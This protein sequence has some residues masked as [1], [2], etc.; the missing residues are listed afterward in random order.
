VTISVPRTN[1]LSNTCTCLRGLVTVTATAAAASGLTIVSVAFQSSLSGN[2]NWTT[3]DTE[4]V[5]STGSTYTANFDTS[6]LAP[7]FYDVRAV[8]TDSAA[9][10]QASTP[11]RGLAIAN[12]ASTVTLADPGLLASG[13]IT[14]TATPDGGGNFPSQV[15]F[16]SSPAGA[17]N[18]STIATVAT[19]YDEFGNPLSPDLVT[20]FD[21]TTVPDGSYDL[22]VTASDGFNAYVGMVRFGV[23]VDNTPPTSTLSNP[24]GPLSGIVTLTASTQDSSGVVAVV[25]QSS[26]AG[27]GTWT[28]IGADSTAPYAKTFDT[29]ALQDGVY[30][31]RVLATDSAGNTA[32]SP[33][34]SGV[35]VSNPSK[36]S[37]GNLTITDFVA[38]ATNISLLGEIAGSAQHETWAYGY[39]TAPPAIV[40]GAPLPYTV[41]GAN[42]LV[43]LRY[44][45]A[46]GWQI[47]DV[48]RNADGS[49]YRQT[50]G[51]ALELTGQMNPSGEAWLVMRQQV[52]GQ[53]TRVGV[54]HRAPGGQFLLDVAASVALLPILSSNQPAIQVQ[55]RLGQSADG[56]AYG[57]LVAPGQA[58]RTLL[59]PNSNGVNFLVTARLDYGV[60]GGGVWT[61][62]TA[63]LPPGYVP[64]AG[65]SFTLAAADATG[66]GA[67]WAGLQLVTFGKR[68]GVILASFDATGWRFVTATGLDALDATGNFAVAPP[69]SVFVQQIRADSAGI[70]VLATVG[71]GGGSVVA[72]IDGASGQA[73]QSWC[74]SLPRQSLGCDAPLD[75][76]HPAALP[77]AVFATTNGTVAFALASGLLDVY[78]YGAWTST[79]APGFVP[80]PGKALFIAPNDGWLVGANALGRISARSL[81]SPL[82]PWPEANRS[83]LLSVA[84]PPGGNGTSANGALAVGLDG[85][86]LHYDTSAGWIVDAT[87]PRAHHLALRG[88]AFSGPSSATAVGQ[89]GVILRWDGVSWTEDPQSISLTYQQLNAVAFGADGQGWA[90]GAHGTILHYDG[91][92]WSQ[93]QVD[94]ADAGVDITSVAVA[95]QQVFAVADGNLI[96]RGPGGVWQ[97]VDRSLLP[98]QAPSVGDLRLVSGLPD[99]GLVAAGRSLVIVRQSASAPFQYAAQPLEGIAVALAA[100]RAA[101]GQVRAL[102]SIAPPIIGSNGLNT[103]DVGGFPAGDGELMLQT[104]AGWEDLS[105]AQYP[106]AHAPGDGSVQPDPVLAVAAAPDGSSAWAVGGYAGTVTASGLGTHQ[107]L[108]S[109]PFGWRTS[110][111]WRY[112]AGGSVPSPALSAAPATLP[113]QPGTVSFAF[114]TSP[115]CK[116]ECA[117]VRDAQPVV[118]LQAA[119][120]QIAGFATQPGGPGFAV[121]GGD[122]VGPIDDNAYSAG[123]GAVDL[124]RLAGLLSPLGSVPLF[125]AY[126]PRDGVP[127]GTNPAQPWADAFAQAPAPFGQGKVPPG[128]TLVSFGGATGSV[129]RYYAFDATQNGG[130]LR[131]IVLDNSAGSLEDSVP[132][133]TAWLDARLA[134]AQAAGIPV[135]VVVARPLRSTAIGSAS[136]GDAIAAKLATAGALAV[137]TTSGTVYQSQFDRVAVLPGTQIPE[138]EGATLGYQQPQNNGVLWYFVSVD[139]KARKVGVQAIPV[140]A[141]LALEPLAGLTA[142][143][144]STL[145]F[146]AIGRRPVATLATIDNTFPGYDSY[147]S[148]PSPNCA[149]CITPSYSFASSDPTIG[150]FVLP[151]GPGSLYPLLDN[152]G[153]PIPSASSGL[154]CAYNS[155]TTTVSVT[156]GGLSA[157]LP[158]NVKP[159][160]IGRP[161]GTVFRAGVQHV[162]KIPVTQVL[163]RPAGPSTQ[164]APPPPPPAAAPPVKL[165]LPAIVPPPPP[166]IQAAPAPAPKPAPT[167]PPAPAPKLAPPPAPV[168]VPVPVPVPQL[169]AVVATPPVAVPPIPPAVT[170][171]PPGGASA[172]AQATARRE[173]KARRHASQSAY[174]IRPAD[175][176]GTDWFYPALGV[177]SVLAVL[178]AAGGLAGPRPRKALLAWEPYD[179]QRRRRRR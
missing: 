123:N 136:D 32:A 15:T 127:T 85:S 40:G 179:P 38:P 88:V 112:D 63:S 42:Q 83:P 163:T 142:A 16:Q 37:Y 74:G 137:F 98:A 120:A 1:D 57:L 100:F 31:L 155:G 150:D 72:R 122:A 168:P 48:L 102:V 89:L 79:A 21:T 33:V 176:P 156:A 114:F 5:P 164:P 162:V 25:F 125:A 110:T 47:A 80:G 103:R 175:V 104:G 116:I 43:L 178:L 94:A 54:F 145:S 173:E 62:H 35:A 58:S 64:S 73:I 52:Q 144:G 68:P 12:G 177:V 107:S 76:N 115:M 60:L 87:P 92:A 171:V 167:P 22:R 6:N 153:N 117:A 134:E 14:L 70:W 108:L 27:S 97:P 149:G 91:A 67:G 30:D 23:V 154:F 170:P 99:G 169:V 130:V 113:A 119:L 141:T 160:D 10:S 118:N 61:R 109:R 143:R 140:V 152:A 146:Q 49:A 28:T 139:T 105:R 36:V 45:D 55:L 4:T 111:I 50:S 13:T 165:S 69:V 124:A 96:M 41:P 46:G 131:V 77:G 3:F 129:H 17:E 59:V 86:A 56:T 128:I 24:G 66:P 82:A 26:P 9:A 135:V 132:G 126:G 138:Y 34:V 106:G 19:A 75:P 71:V 51:A 161:C 121:L 148:I 65:D 101:D 44:T 11:A 159:G 172:S 90:V 78:A 166:T 7:D 157:S 147:V 39:T 81:P 18:W 174:V 133:Q 151:S 8:A 29:R 93:E 95:G 158:V 2:N 20:S 84:L 53:P